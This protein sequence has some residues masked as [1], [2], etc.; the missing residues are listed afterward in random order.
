[1]LDRRKRLLQPFISPRNGSFQGV[2][3]LLLL[4]SVFGQNSFRYSFFLTLLSVNLSHYFVLVTSQYN[5]HHI[6]SYLALYNILVKVE[7]YY[8]LLY[9]FSFLE[10]QLFCTN[11]FVMKSISIHLFNPLWKCYDRLCPICELFAVL[12][13]LAI[14]LHSLFSMS[15]IFFYFI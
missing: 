1:M 15:R 11:Y 12:S 4:V 7:N 9:V 10:W 14:P 8:T 2:G 13:L 3:F 6:E 5:T